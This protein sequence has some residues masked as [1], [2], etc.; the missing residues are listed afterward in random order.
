MVIVKRHREVKMD[1][2]FRI[3]HFSKVYIICLGYICKRYKLTN[4]EFMSV[5][6]SNDMPNFLL[7]LMCNEISEDMKGMIGKPLKD[8][9]PYKPW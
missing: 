8:M 7:H 5:V 2:L 1:K 6:L 4:D 3:L 9:I